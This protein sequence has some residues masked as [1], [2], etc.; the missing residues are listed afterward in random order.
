M[1]AAPKILVVDDEPK[2]CEFLETLLQQDGYA[3]EAAESGD[4]AI[5]K[6]SSARYDLIISD[7]KM[8]GMDGFE[9]AKRV[10]GVREDLP[11]VIVTGYATVGTAIQ[12][13]RQGVDDYVTKPFKIDEMRKVVARVLEKS[14]LEGENRRL[15]AE[16]EAANAELK[17]HRAS[18]A[19]KVKLTTEDLERANADLRQRVHELGV[20][21]EVGACAASALDLDKLLLQEVR[22]IAEKLSVAKLC[23]LLREGEWLVAKACQGPETAKNIGNKIRVGA[24]AVGRA[25]SSREPIVLKD[26]GADAAEGEWLQPA[27]SL[28]CVPIVYKEDNLGVMCAADKRSDEPFSSSDIRVLGTIA[29][30][31]APAIE[32]AR[33]YKRLEESS[34]ATVRALVAGLEAKDPYLYGHALRV[35]SYAL[36]IGAALGMK[37]RQLSVLE[38][39]GQLHDLGKLGIS[40]VILNKP[41]PLTPAEY[42]SV[43]MHP[44]YGEEIIQH[45]DFLS[46]VRPVIRHHHERVDG[47]GYP[48]GKKGDEIELLARVLSVADAFDAMTSPRPYRPAKDVAEAQKEIAALRAKQFDSEVADVFCEAVVSRDSGTAQNS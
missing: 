32:N 9:L 31:I 42:E 37:K 40:D 28:V 35:T 48:D 16:L 10:K 8:P 1:V 7:L 22:L 2:I 18:L 4:A 26:I 29:S 23:I 44:V 33:L 15:V 43:K 14:R 46:D 20:L 45:L 24:G 27:H 25:A 13:L 36:A 30:Q 21:N 39:A 5:A 34:Y 11:V 17:K 12:A 47:R 38:R 19:D 6:V 41:S 3:T